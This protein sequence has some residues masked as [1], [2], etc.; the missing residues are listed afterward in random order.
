MPQRAKLYGL[1]ETN[2][3]RK[4]SKLWSK[5]IFNST[6]PVSLALYMRDHN[7]RAKYIKL[8]EDLSTEVS[9]IPID[10]LFGIVGI[11]SD[12]VYFDFESKYEKYNQYVPQDKPLTEKEKTDLVVRRKSDMTP[13]VPLEIKL[14]VVPDKTTANKA[15]EKQG[16]EL[17][18][19]PVTTKYCALSIFSRLTEDEREQI[20]NQFRAAYK[21]INDWNHPDNMDDARRYLEQLK[22]GFDAFERHFYEKQVPLI[23]QP[24][25]RTDGQTVEINKDH[26]FD[27]FVWSDYAYTRLFLD[28]EFVEIKSYFENENGEQVKKRREELTRMAR[29]MIRVAGY[30]YDAGRDRSNR[31]DI[32]M[33]FA[34]YTATKQSDKDMSAPASVT[35]PFMT[36]NA[37][38]DENCLLYPRIAR[39][40]LIEIIKNGGHKRLQPERRLDQS[41]FFTFNKI[42]KNR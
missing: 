39:V 19:R 41:I 22:L 11:D 28:R 14:T 17:V 4:V 5:N 35:F 8:R 40:A 26:A 15:V 10:E 42:R 23:M 7:I 13:L 21:A 24:I 2:N 20:S 9:E 37:D 16:S 30:L 34:K 12:D 25:W 6:F 38:P 29:C 18:C 33:I 32:N 31:A 27:I 1:T 3:S 36:L